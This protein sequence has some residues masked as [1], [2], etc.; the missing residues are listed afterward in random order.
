MLR[1]PHQCLLSRGGVLLEAMLEVVGSRVGVLEAELA[2][3]NQ[4]ITAQAL[5]TDEMMLTKLEEGSLDTIASRI[6]VAEEVLLTKLDANSLDLFCG[7]V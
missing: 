7:Q 1:E 2:T 6:H 3:L 4:T 5:K